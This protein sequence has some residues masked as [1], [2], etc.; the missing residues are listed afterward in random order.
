MGIRLVGDNVTVG[1][2]TYA[3]ASQIAKEQG[4]DLVKISN[5]NN[6]VAVFK[7]LDKTKYLYEKKKQ[8]KQNAKKQ[9]KTVVK[10]IRVTP[11]IS[12]NDL[13]TKINQA[14]KFAKKDFYIKA[15]VFFKGRSFYT[16]KEEGEK[17]LLLLADALSECYIPQALPKAEGRKLVMH[18]KPKTK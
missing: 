13:N 14:L 11:N 9:I 1:I 18:L 17:K 3:D 12:E 8:K 16:Q 2:Y 7:I 10:E 5:G 15:S 6:D 4:L